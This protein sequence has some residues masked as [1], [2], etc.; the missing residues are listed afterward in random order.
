MTPY[1]VSY[2]Q[3]QPL[4][5]SYIPSTSKVHA[6]DNMLDNLESILHILKEN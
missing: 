6:M 5:V 4:V 1:E 2:G 3:Q